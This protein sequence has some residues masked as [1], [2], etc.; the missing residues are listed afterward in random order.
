MRLRVLKHCLPTSREPASRNVNLKIQMFFRLLQNENV[1]SRSDLKFAKALH[2]RPHCA[3]ACCYMLGATHCLNLSGLYIL[4]NFI[5]YFKYTSNLW[6]VLFHPFT[7]IHP[8]FPFKI[9]KPSP[10][11]AQ[12]KKPPMKQIISG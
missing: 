12:K 4:R 11:L 1:N 8:C 9:T 7:S 5:F 10:N 6:C 2:V 3:M